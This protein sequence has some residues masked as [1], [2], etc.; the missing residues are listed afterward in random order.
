[1]G[2]HLEKLLVSGEGFLNTGRSG[3]IY[4]LRGMIQKRLRE[5]IM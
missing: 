5:M 1:M 4:V 3:S 2:H